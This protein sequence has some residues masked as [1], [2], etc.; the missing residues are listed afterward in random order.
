M[1]WSIRTRL[2]VTIFVLAAI[3]S[4]VGVLAGSRT[5]EGQIEDRAI[6]ERLS[7][8]EQ[9]LQ[10]RLED[11]SIFFD[12]EPSINGAGVTAEVF[13]PEVFG[14]DAEL[15][16]D[17]LLSV[18]SD[19]E[20]VSDELLFELVAVDEYG[21]ELL[22]EFGASDRLYV[23]GFTGTVY[24]IDPS[25]KTVELF[26]G[27]SDDL[28][29]VTAGELANLVEPQF[30]FN[31][32][33]GSGL[34]FEDDSDSD[35]DDS[36]M[37]VWRIVEVDG[38][39][40]GVV[41]DI[42]A[43]IET[44]DAVK[45]ALWAVAFFLPFLA[46]IATWFITGRALRPVAAI[47][48][49]VGEISSQNLSGRVP[50]TGKADEIGGLAST[51]NAMLAR[52]ENGDLRR[53]QFVSDASHELRTP[54]AV[55]RSEAEVAKKAPDSTTINR[56]ADVVMGETRR[57]GVVVEDLL[58]LA[59]SDESSASTRSIALPELD[60]DDLVLE[61]ADRSRGID[62]DRSQVSAGRVRGD[63]EEISRLIGHLLDN[64]ARHAKQRVVIGLKTE[65]DQV[66]LWVDDDGAGIAKPDRERVFQRF[67]RLDEARTSDKGGSGLGLAVVRST[68]ERLGG[69]IEIE[70]SPIGG[71]RFMVKLPAA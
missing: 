67:V 39:R 16:D 66:M 8:V 30:N 28:V 44:I 64:A 34:D 40:F 58:S 43:E 14:A 70:D 36:E 41:A 15:F 13:F 32:V 48:E 71:A 62:L 19:W 18:I 1:S 61:Q 6:E 68:V 10:F 7:V 59:R 63:S 37:L 42:R 57:L 31:D 17:D 55:L 38:Q 20:L 35:G 53:R 4:V 12:S 24:E 26:A 49:Q 52:I 47:T 21:E 51:M 2:T 5:L 69:R 65:G 3:V 45:A 56:F 22:D 33:F 27:A 50:E 60:L 9:E 46:G 23:Q 29:L 11:D 25:A 54:V